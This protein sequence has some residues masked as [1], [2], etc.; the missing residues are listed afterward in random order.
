M[1]GEMLGL[2]GGM[3]AV[4]PAGERCWRA[5]LGSVEVAIVRLGVGPRRARVRTTQALARWPGAR[6]WNLGTCGALVAGLGRGEVLV[7]G[8]LRDEQG[9]R[10]ILDGPT[11]AGGRLVTVRRPVVEPARRAALA[12]Q[13]AIAC[14]MEAFAIHEACLAAGRE[15]RVV[16]VVSDQAGGEDDAALPASPGRMETFRA[17]ARFSWRAAGLVH[18]ALLPRLP[19]LGLGSAPGSG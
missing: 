14:D 12:A 11:G 13:G 1:H 18:G 10:A 17:T 5:R 7:F 8:E 15:L 4:R 6:V 3:S 19:A 2:L 16:K 9:G